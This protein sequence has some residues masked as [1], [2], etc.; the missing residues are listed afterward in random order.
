MNRPLQSQDILIILKIVATGGQRPE[1]TAL[2]KSLN[3]SPSQV[4]A[5]IRR[6]QSSSLLHADG[7]GGLPNTSAL[8]EFLVHGLK[9]CFPLER[10][11]IVRGMPT[12]YAAPPLNGWIAVGE[13]PVPVWPYPDGSATGIGFAPLYATVPFAACGDPV[14]YEYL[15]L[16]D[17]IRGGRARDRRLA[18]TELIRRLR[19]ARTARADYSV[20]GLERSCASSSRKLEQLP[21]PD[22]PGSVDGDL[23]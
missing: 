20:S 19:E 3:I 9:Y 2:A 6:L 11:G 23:A 7:L 15:A 16:V 13:D 17:A 1:P 21:Q 8:E 22:R 10:G 4:Q 5:S 18:G 14:L 12:S